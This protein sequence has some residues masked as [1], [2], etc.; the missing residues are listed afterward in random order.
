MIVNKQ[1]GKASAK[2][3]VEEFLQGIEVSVFVLTDG[4]DYTIIGHAKDYKRIGEGDTGLNTGGMGCVS[5]VPFVDEDFMQKI[6]DSII[7]PTVKGLN[8]EQLTYEGFIFFGL[9]K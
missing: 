6:E 4:V 8:E 9:I 7:K 5:P 1:F 3:V 2:V